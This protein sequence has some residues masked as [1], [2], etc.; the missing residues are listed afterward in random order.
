MPRFL[1][2]HIIFDHGLVD[3][4]GPDQPL[5]QG[6]L[7]CRKDWIQL[8]IIA[9]SEW[10]ILSCGI[11]D[12]SSPATTNNAEFQEA[13]AAAAETTLLGGQGAPSLCAAWPSCRRSLGVNRRRPHAAYGAEVRRFGACRHCGT[14]ALAQSPGLHL[15]WHNQIATVSRVQ[16]LRVRYSSPRTSCWGHLPAQT[17]AWAPGRCGQRNGIRSATSSELAA[18]TSGRQHASGLPSSRCR[19]D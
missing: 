16:I 12:P 19:S 8:R 5:L 15:L 4:L 6:N 9:L 14:T 11:S 2:H 10:V 7:L 13:A 1:L 17:T 3:G 18:S